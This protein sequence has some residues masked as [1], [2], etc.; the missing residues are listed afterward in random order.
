MPV[1]A[2]ML[3][4]CVLTTSTPGPC[5]W[6]RTRRAAALWGSLCSGVWKKE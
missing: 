2:V 6:V 3:T 4:W 1:S 5:H